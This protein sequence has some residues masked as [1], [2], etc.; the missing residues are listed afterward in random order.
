MTRNSLKQQA[1]CR[2]VLCC[3]FPVSP[4]PSVPSQWGEIKKD[5]TFLAEFGQYKNNLF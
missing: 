1:D 5:R 2:P 3:F 4:Q